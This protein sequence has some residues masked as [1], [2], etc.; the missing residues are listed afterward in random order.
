M[1]DN[2]PKSYLLGIMAWHLIVRNQ[3]GAVI[4]LA[5]VAQAPHAAAD[6]VDGSRTS[7]PD[8]D[9][10]SRTIAGSGRRYAV[11]QDMRDG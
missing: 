7:C 6:L 1:H 3:S 5:S 2:Q 4:D 8:Y 11:E 10:L 9:W